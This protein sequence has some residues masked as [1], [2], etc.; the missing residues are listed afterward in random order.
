[1]AWTLDVPRLGAARSAPAAAKPAAPA[2]RTGGVAVG[3]PVPSYRPP[4]PAAA[5]TPNPVAQPSAAP[6]PSAPPPPSM[7]AQAFNPPSPAAPKA[8][9]KQEPAP[10]F[11]STVNQYISQAAAAPMPA[12]PDQDD[13]LPASM[14][15]IG[16]STRPQQQL[17]PPSKFELNPNLGKR[18]YPESMNAIASLGRRAY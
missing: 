6:R 17:L 15:P 1:M 18:I 7:Q 16:T 10:A 13:G 12:M 3:P 14:A 5:P 11:T 8:A 2:A 4:A 9:A